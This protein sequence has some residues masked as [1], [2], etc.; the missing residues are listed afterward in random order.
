[1]LIN[2][3]PRHCRNGNVR[4]FQKLPILA[5]FGPTPARKRT[6]IRI[7]QSEKTVHRNTSQAR[8]PTLLSLSSAKIN[9]RRTFEKADVGVEVRRQWS[10][11][12]PRHVRVADVIQTC[13]GTPRHDVVDPVVESPSG[14]RGFR[15]RKGI[16]IRQPTINV[17]GI[18]KAGP[19][20]LAMVVQTDHGARTGVPFRQCG[21]HERA[22]ER[23]GDN[24]RRQLDACETMF[25]KRRRPA[26]LGLH[27]TGLALP[28]PH[29]IAGRGEK[30]IRNRMHHS[31]R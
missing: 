13:A 18:K 22:Q 21:Q 11:L 6:R 23:D 8:A 5:A 16:I 15:R 9:I 31:S 17:L 2:R 29:S 25:G 1:M 14:D 28:R 30:T 3:E 26:G 20:K 7:G 19:R 12:R 4:G 24:H 27:E 10:I